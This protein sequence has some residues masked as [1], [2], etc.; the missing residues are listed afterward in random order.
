MNSIVILIILVVLLST[1][2]IVAIAYACFWKKRFKAGTMQ[3]NSESDSDK[4]L[5]KLENKFQLAIH[6][7]N[8]VQWEYNNMTKLFFSS[9]ERIKSMETILTAEDYFRAIH[10]DDANNVKY[11]LDRMD[12]GIDESFIFNK[13]LI[14]SDDGKYHYTTVFG[15]PFEKDEYGKVIKYTGFRRDDTEWKEM[16]DRLEEERKKA[17]EADMLKSAFLANMSHEIRTPL[18]AIVGF[19]QMLQFTETAKEREEFIEII[20]VNNE[21]LL[22]LINDILD[23]SKIES[24]MMELKRE[25]FDFV[26]FFDDFATALKQRVTNPE[27]EFIVDNPFKKCI[28]KFD[29]NRMAQIFTNFT[30]NAIKYTSKGHIK[31]GY[32]YVDDGIRIYVEDTGIGIPKEKH[33]RVFRRFEKLDDFAQGTGLGLSICKAIMDTIDAKIGFDS[34]P[35]KGSTFWAWSKGEGEIIV[36]EK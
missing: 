29:K 20:N 22:R 31:V 11:Y 7:S 28:V 21:L 33:D 10:P 23:L 34:E 24:G 4:E 32:E 8:L 36:I 2:S 9:N 12:E 30:T 27:V 18:N 15:A 35:G 16:N 14:Y 26:P 19:S 3:L 13:R 1:T 5:E 17:Q 6:T 25:S